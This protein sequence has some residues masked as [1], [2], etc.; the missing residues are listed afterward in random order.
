MEEVEV[1]DGFDA[2]EGFAEG[3]SDH[4]AKREVGRREGDGVDA[5]V[6]AE[7]QGAKLVEP[8]GDDGEVAAVEHVAGADDGVECPQAV[9]VED[10]GGLGDAAVEQGALEFHRLVMGF[11]AA[12]DQALDFAGAIEG[13]GGVDATEEMLVDAAAFDPFARGEDKAVAIDGQGADVGEDFGSGGG[14]DPDVAGQD[15]EQ[16]EGRG[17]QRD[18]GGDF[19]EM[20]AVVA[21]WLVHWRGMLLARRAFDKT[22]GCAARKRLARNF[23]LRQSAGG[24]V[25]CGANRLQKG[26]R[27]SKNVI[28]FHYTLTDQTGKTLDASAEGE[29][30]TFLEEAGQIIPGLEAEIR[31]MKVGDK[32]HVT[33][34]AKDAY[35]EH[36]AG[37]VMEVPLEKMP[38]KG[39][40]VGDRFRAGKDSHAPVVTATKVT[41]THVTLDGNHPLAG[42]DLT[43][44]VEITEVRGATEDELAHGHVHGPG[45]HHH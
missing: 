20:A 11:V 28:S 2:G 34:K 26:L 24:V 36:D 44:D 19:L 31:G 10:E 13:R 27:V 33:I 30:M 35:G 32:K 43:F 25:R 14:D 1:E 37:N 40:K 21:R 17:G 7:E 38:A 39:I 12:E 8:L 22:S 16:Q 23:L 29:P 3:G 5:V 9:V 15:E 18:D 6:A 41:Q 45:G 42:M 4:P